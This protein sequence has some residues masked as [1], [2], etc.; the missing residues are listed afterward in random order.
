LRHFAADAL[1]GH[2]LFEIKALDR[3]LPNL[4]QPS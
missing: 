1:S 2:V 3:M 4:C